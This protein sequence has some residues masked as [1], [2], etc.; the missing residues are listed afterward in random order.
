MTNEEKYKFNSN[1]FQSHQILKLKK[2][3]KERN[4]NH[5][6]FRLFFVCLFFQ[7]K[8]RLQNNK[9][10]KHKNY[11]SVRIF[12]FVVTIFLLNFEN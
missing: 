3:M 5:F 11:F 9:E 6:V 10:T 1:S 2:E 8:C 12:L 4:L 7:S